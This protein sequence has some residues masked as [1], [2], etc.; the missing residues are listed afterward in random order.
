MFVSFSIQK[1]CSEPKKNSSFIS[2]SGFKDST[3]TPTVLVP[4]GHDPCSSFTQFFWEKSDYILKIIIFS[5][6]WSTGPRHVGHWYM[7][8]FFILKKEQ[9]CFVLS[10]PLK[11]RLN[12]FFEV[13]AEFL[14]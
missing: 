3:F 11:C 14:C 4:R 2:I 10:L 9:C 6:E 1:L 12:V 5:F 7:M 8:K 13:K